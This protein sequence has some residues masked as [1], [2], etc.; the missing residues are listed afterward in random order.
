VAAV[1][2]LGRRGR[3]PN[4]FARRAGVSRSTVSYALSGKRTVGARTRTL[5]LVIPPASQRLT[6]MQ[7]RR[8]CARWGLATL[9]N[10]VWRLLGKA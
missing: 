10:Q 2:L 6:D 5:G 3:W 1:A 4:R 9:K 8:R 7:L